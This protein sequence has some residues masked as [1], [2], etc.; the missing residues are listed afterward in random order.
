MDDSTDE[1]AAP[2]VQKPS[3][4]PTSKHRHFGEILGLNHN[5]YTLSSPWEYALIGRSVCTHSRASKYH[6]QDILYLPH[7]HPPKL[8]LTSSK[9]IFL[10]E[11]FLYYN[12]SLLL[13]Q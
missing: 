1:Y 12:K 11:N 7:V 6:S 8:K 2:I 5:A 9:A 4:S 10:G 3:K 13:K